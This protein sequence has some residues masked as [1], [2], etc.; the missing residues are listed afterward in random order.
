MFLAPAVD[1]LRKSVN[2]KTILGEILFWSHVPVLL[3]WFGL[4]FVPSSMIPDKI[5]F[6]FWYVIVLFFVQ[7]AWGVVLYPII[8]KFDVGVCPLTTLNQWVRGYPIADRRNYDHWFIDEFSER[9][10][11]SLPKKVLLFL[12]IGSIVLV[13]VQYFFFA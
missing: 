13:A 6:H 10:G 1:T 8:K 11:I 5:V 3:V 12:F 9:L 4:F 7:I 2:T